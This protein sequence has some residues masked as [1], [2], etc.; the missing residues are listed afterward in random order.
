MPTFLPDYEHSSEYILRLADT[1]NQQKRQSVHQKV[2][3]MN[4][5]GLPLT[6][7]AMTVWLFAAPIVA[8]NRPNILFAISDDQS[9]PHAS[10]YGC[11][12][13]KTP[14]FDRVAKSGVLFTNAFAPTPGC[15]PT[16]ACILTGRHA[17]QNREAGTHASSFPADLPVFTELLASNG[18]H[19]GATGKGWAPG[20]FRASGRKQNPAGKSW[21]EH[22]AKPPYAGMSNNDYAANFADFL[23]NKPTEAPFC[24]W[25]GA[26]EPHRSFEKIKDPGSADI[27]TISVPPYL[28]DV[29]EVRADLR[30]YAREVEWFDRHIERM[31]EQLQQ[32]GELKS[33]IVIVTSDNGMSFPRAKANVYEDG[34]HMPLAI[35][36]P[37]QVPP[38][39][40]SKDL[41][42]LIDIAPT[43]LEAAGVSVPDTVSGTSLVSLLKSEESGIIEPQRSA[44]FAA[45]ERH[46]SVRYHSLGYPQRAIRTHRYLYIRN[47][48]PERWPAGA[49]QKLGSANYPSREDLVKR[50]LGPMHGGYHDID[51]CPTLTLMVNRR[52]EPTFAR[53]LELAVN[54]RPAE[55][56]FDI[57]NDPACM[58][59]LAGTSAIADTQ[60]EL[61]KRLTA[62][63][64]ETGDPREH[65]NGDVFETYP[66]YSGIRI[67]PEPKWAQDNPKS[68]PTQPWFDKRYRS[69]TEAKQ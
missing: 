58:T 32:R 24:F 13:I 35:S 51:A 33:T 45:R 28:P 66:R 52:E 6:L 8:Q 34:I 22:K 48:K 37:A 17:W 26:S 47:N 15:S 55:E 11:K 31:L 59:N 21:R 25:F 30:A 42:S 4:L 68:V 23:E 67:F 18:Y 53:A 62:K 10:A 14:G 36:W 63:L 57:E 43:I 20:N 1:P 9:F 61:S 46:S 65:G 2:A 3:K 56:L 12:W 44:V 69:M 19:V 41:V 16:R 5:R 39:R 40:T 64:K 27:N 54:H 60:R 38:E 29:R 7:G 49:A 50:T